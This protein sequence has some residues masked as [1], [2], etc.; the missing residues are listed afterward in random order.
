MTGDVG[1]RPMDLGSI[2][3]VAFVLYRRYF[4]AIVGTAAVVTVPLALL[5]SPVVI[6]NNDNLSALSTPIEYVMSFLIA[7]PIAVA[8]DH[9]AHGG[10]PTIGGAWRRTGPRLG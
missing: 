5:E 1:R 4:V 8:I 6:S 2:L 7:A 10:T 9:A 3:D